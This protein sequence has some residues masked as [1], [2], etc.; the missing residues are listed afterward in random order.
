MWV[1]AGAHTIGVARCSSFKARLSNFDS[2]HDIDPSMNVNLAK[3]LS[4]T[5]AAGDRAEQPLD[6]SRNTFDNAYFI[7]LQQRAGVLFSDQSLF[8]SPRTRP[9]VNDYAMN[10]A[11]F[12]MDFQLAM[13][14]MSFLNVKEGYAGEVRQNCRRIN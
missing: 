10:E 12:A 4:R 7:A 1:S 6:P 8:S 14:K 2:T 3:A 13:Q 9:I 11:M 5:C